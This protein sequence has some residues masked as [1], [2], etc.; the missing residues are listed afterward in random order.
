MRLR[1]RRTSRSRAASAHEPRGDSRGARR[2]ARHADPRRRSRRRRRR[3]SRRCPGCARAEVE[4]LLPDTIFVRLAE[5]QPLAFWQRQRQARARSTA[6]ARSSPTDDLD[7]FGALVVLV[8]DDAPRA[9]PRR[10]STC[11]RPSPRSQPHVA[12]AV[13]VGGRRW[14]MRA[15]Q[16]HRRGAARSRTPESAW[17]RL[18]ALERSDKLLERDILAVDLRLPDRLVLRLPPEPPKPRRQEEPRP[19]ESRHDEA[20]ASPA[21]SGRR[22]PPSISAPPR[23][24]A[25]SPALDGDEP[26]IVGIGHQISR[27]VQQRRHRRYRGGEPFDPHRRPCR[28]A[29]GRR[30]DRRGGGQYLRRLRRLA[31]RQGRD[32][33]E[34]PRDQRQRH[35]PRARARL[36]AQGAAR[37]APSSIPCPVGFSIDGSRGIR[38][39][40]G[41]FGQ[42]AR[43]QH[44]RRHRVRRRPAQPR[45][46]H[47]ALPSRDRGAGREPLCRGPRRARRGRERARRHR[48]RHGRRHHHHRRVLR[49]QSGLHRLRAGGRRPRHQRHRPRPVDAASPMPSA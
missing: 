19:G 25:S 38:D 29:D 41:M 24:A 14:N 33:R 28:R 44:E 36:P 17:H 9:R 1:R 26:R 13:R 3:G 7:A 45:E 6:T 37:T 15:R 35:A 49:R 31:P 4:R 39:P 16:R 32:R 27:G 46:L 23:S 30:A 2:R 47:R 48:H 18:A 11:S 42:Q 12:A 34:R 10:C 21:A 8:G 20:R 40:R 22:S 5:R 43:R